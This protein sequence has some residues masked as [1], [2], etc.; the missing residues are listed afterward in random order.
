[1]PA[2]I[3]SFFHDSVQ[4]PNVA[5][6]LG[7][8]FATAD[9]HT[10]DLLAGQV[11][12]LSGG[13]FQGRVEG[14]HLRLTNVVTATQVTIRLSLDSNGDFTLVPDTVATLAPGIT[15]ANSACAAFKVD[16][17]IFQIF[18]GGTVYLF[19]KVDAGSADFAQSCV[20]WSET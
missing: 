2:R 20:T 19:A 13:P 11:P 10:H 1:M 5:P 9:V 15:T 6:A 18:G 17:P 14:I 4:A 8:S 12:F 3:R 7:T 16:I